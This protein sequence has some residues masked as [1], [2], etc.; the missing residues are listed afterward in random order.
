LQ[1]LKANHH[2]H[3]GKLLK[4]TSRTYPDQ[5]KTIYNLPSTGGKG[6]IAIILMHTTMHIWNPPRLQGISQRL[7]I[8]LDWPIKNGCL[9]IHKMS[10]TIK[11]NSGWRGENFT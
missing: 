7:S 2:S 8:C 6:T 3:I 1:T 9:E 4:N 11:G 5:I 10:G